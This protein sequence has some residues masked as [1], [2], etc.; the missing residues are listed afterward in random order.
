LRSPDRSVWLEVA[1]PLGTQRSQVSR[2]DPSQAAS[3]T[4]RLGLDGPSRRTVP[5]LARIGLRERDIRRR[6]CP[7]ID[8]KAVRLHRAPFGSSRRARPSR[9]R[10][11]V[12]QGPPARPGEPD[13][14]EY[15]TARAGRRCQS[16]A[17]CP[18][19]PSD[20]SRPAANT[21]H[22]SGSPIAGGPGRSSPSRQP[23][24]NRPRRIPRLSRS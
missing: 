14:P 2:I 3:L 23:H 21:A 1:A 15:R 11:D 12:P 22:R 13:R 4:L 16:S 19:R 20:P 10:A 9:R 6:E 5:E 18:V 24:R 17:V 8:S 7:R